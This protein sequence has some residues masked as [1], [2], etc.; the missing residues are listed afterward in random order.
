MNGFRL[1]ALFIVLGIVS[2]LFSS[3]ANANGGPVSWPPPGDGPLRFDPVSGISLI[4]E[5]VSF[6]FDEELAHPTVNIEYVLKNTLERKTEIQM[7]FITP[8]FQDESLQVHEGERKVEASFVADVQIN[9]WDPEVKKDFVEPVSGKPMTYSDR[10]S[11]S[12]RQSVNGHSF[13]L[14]FE[15]TETQKVSMQYTA[16]GGAHRIG[17][18]NEVITQLYYLTPAAYWNGDTKAELSIHLPARHYRVHSNIPLTQQDARTYQARLDRLPDVEWYFSLT[19]T[20]GLVFGTNDSLVHNRFIAII[21]FALILISYIQAIRYRRG[22]YMIFGAA[23]SLLVL[24]QFVRSIDGQYTSD[25]F[26]KLLLA[27]LLAGI[28]GVGLI[29][30]HILKLAKRRTGTESSLIKIGFE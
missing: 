16:Y 23:A 26:L 28:F 17:T 18:V 12:N 4:R 11:G 3:L 1:V 8:A 25:N 21:I 5:Q 20:T 6:H 27:L 29:V 7:M 14:S 15:P 24:F 10:Y 19:D 22:R 2:I 30:V 9:G 13:E